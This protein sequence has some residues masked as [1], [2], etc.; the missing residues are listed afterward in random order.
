MDTLTWRRARLLAGALIL[1]VLLWRVGAG[2]FVDGLRLTDPR[3]VVVAVLVS[4]ASTLA[5]AWRWSLVAG[6]LGPGLS[7]RAAYAACYRAQVLNVT[8][9]GGVLGDV[10]RGVR[11][12]R[13]TGALATGVRSVVWDRASGQ[14]VQALLCLAA[15]PLLPGSAARAVLLL[16]GVGTVVALA[17]AVLLPRRATHILH[18]DL[19]ALLASPAVWPRIVLAAVLATVGQVVVLLL[20]AHSVGV[21]VPLTELVPVAMV[22]LLVSAVPLSVAGW[23]PREGAAAWAFVVLGPGAGVGV[24]VAVVYGVLSLV[25]TA[26]GVA[27][28][29]LP[30]RRGSPEPAEEPLVEETARG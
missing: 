13:D 30:G 26:P 18:A 12:G 22:V 25:A 19:R 7:V 16:A 9:P 1:L 27:L 23:G 29:L 6:R 11:H 14:A 28:L 20:A 15:V 21:D 2:P 4:A 17:A 3:T 8:L 5:C 24:T 10:H